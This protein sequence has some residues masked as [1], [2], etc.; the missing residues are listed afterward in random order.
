MHEGFFH[1][2]GYRFF[3]GK[4]VHVLEKDLGMTKQ[5]QD[6]SFFS[7]DRKQRKKILVDSHS[8]RPLQVTKTMVQATVHRPCPWMW[9][10]YTPM[11]AIILLVNTSFWFVYRACLQHA[12]F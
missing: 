3:D 11:T 4:G 10:A 5:Y 2:L 12:Y 1:I 6:Q 9:C 8:E 7:M